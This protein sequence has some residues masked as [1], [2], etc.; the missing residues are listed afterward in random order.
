MG[1]SDTQKQTHT[2]THTHAHTHI[3]EPSIMLSLRLVSSWMLNE[4]KVGKGLSGYVHTCQKEGDESVCRRAEMQD[5]I[6]TK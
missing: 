3:E 1:A 2:H 6:G 5:R 4:E